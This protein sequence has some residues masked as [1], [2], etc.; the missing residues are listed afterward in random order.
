MNKLI[1]LHN[2]FKKARILSK[3]EDVVL[4]NEGQ[5]RFELR[6]SIPNDRL[7]LIRSEVDRFNNQY[8]A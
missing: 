6:S 2:I 4:V 5:K 7:G 3:R 8:R 1:S